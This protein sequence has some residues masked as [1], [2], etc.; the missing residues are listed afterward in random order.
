MICRRKMTN[1]TGAEEEKAR[2]KN[3]KGSGV[4][5]V[6]SKKKGQ[7]ECMMLNCLPQPLLAG[8][9]KS[10]GFGNWEKKRR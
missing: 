8:G 3:G 7:Q 1:R 2:L 5:G 10:W 6:V 4:G 9:E